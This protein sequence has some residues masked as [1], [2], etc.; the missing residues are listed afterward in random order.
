MDY[1]VMVFVGEFSN[2]S[3]FS[4]VLLMLGCPERSSFSTDTQ[5]ALKCE[6]SPKP[7]VQLKE[8]PPKSHDR[9][10]DFW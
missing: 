10:Q 4:V 8:C 5:P 9:F 1:L 3:I 2:F 7:A 6:C